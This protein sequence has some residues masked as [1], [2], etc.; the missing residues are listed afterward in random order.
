MK[1]TLLLLAVL[2]FA[3][4]TIARPTPPVRLIYNA[5]DSAPRG[6]WLITNATRVQVGD[7]VIADLPAP[8]A[9]LAAERRYLPRNTP[10]LKYIAALAGQRVCTRDRV[11]TI[12]GMALAR[13]LSHDGAG[14][15]LPVWRHC[16]TLADG[17]LF[18][19][20][21]LRSASF[22]SRY[23]GPIPYSAVRGIAHPLVTWGAP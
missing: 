18:L 5:S 2:G 15:K 17:E 12:N 9:A 20:N 10:V 23:F 14:R 7:A 21:P 6:W 3:L 16:R 1:R 8:V 22:D 19:L 4:L 13:A 11:V